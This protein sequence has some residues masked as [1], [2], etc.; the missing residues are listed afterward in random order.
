[1]HGYVGFCDDDHAFGV[2]FDNMV[3]V[4]CVDYTGPV[5]GDLTSAVGGAVVYPK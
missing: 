2:G 1:V 3:E 5:E 4:A